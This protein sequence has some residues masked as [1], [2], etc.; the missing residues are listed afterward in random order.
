MDVLH[1]RNRAEPTGPQEPGLYLEQ[2]E[3]ASFQYV[4][5]PTNGRSAHWTRRAEQTGPK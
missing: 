1:T 2:V 5:H 3:T 4:I